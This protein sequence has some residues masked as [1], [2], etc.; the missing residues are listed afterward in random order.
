[1][2]AELALP[3][4]EG[5]TAPVRDE[6]AE[7]EATAEAPPLTGATSGVGVSDDPELGGVDPA[8]EDPERAD[9]EAEAVLPDT[10]KGKE[11]TLLLPVAIG[12]VAE[13]TLTWAAPAR[14][15]ADAG[16]LAG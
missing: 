15:L 11:F 7:D 16:L 2:D 8:R 1:M 4:R 10:G 3:A 9:K 14:A 12:V 6:E 13:E 5:S